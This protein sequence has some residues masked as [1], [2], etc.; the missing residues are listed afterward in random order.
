V[1]RPE[2]AREHAEG[3]GL[4]V[5]CLVEVFLIGEQ[6]TVHHL[7]GE[8][9]RV[10][11]AEYPLQPVQRQPD[12]LRRLLRVQLLAHQGRQVDVADQ[13]VRV[14]RPEAVLVL[15]EHGAHFGLGFGEPVEGPE[16]D[17]EAQAAG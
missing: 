15:L 5:R 14:V 3:S 16:V 10:L 4:H 13:G 9:I 12:G 11:G 6:D 17:R 2:R 1:R 7:G 8:R